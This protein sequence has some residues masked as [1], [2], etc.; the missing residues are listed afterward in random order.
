[1][2]TPKTVPRIDAAMRLVDEVV[3]EYS[4]V[5]TSGIMAGVDMTQR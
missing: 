2:T 4:G 3:V 1:M 5:A